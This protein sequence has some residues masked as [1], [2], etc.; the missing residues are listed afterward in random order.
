MKNLHGILA[1]A[2]IGALTASAQSV[3]TLTPQEKHSTTTDHWKGTLLFVTCLTDER[4]YHIAV[5]IG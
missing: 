4:S 5:N 1:V 3:G 2:G